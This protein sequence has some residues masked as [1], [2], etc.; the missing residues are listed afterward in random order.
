[1]LCAG[2]QF[3]D[4]RFVARSFMSPERCQMCDRFLVGMSRQA[5][6]CDGMYSMYEILT[7]LLSTVIELVH[8][9]IWHS[10]GA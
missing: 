5:L 1:M 4:H 3:K 2:Q 7:A 10:V 9:L 6:H 8:R